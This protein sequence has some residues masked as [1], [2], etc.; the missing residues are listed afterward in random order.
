LKYAPHFLYPAAASL[1][2]EV[3]ALNRSIDYAVNKAGYK[4]YLVRLQVTLDMKR[5]R[6]PYDVI[7]SIAFFNDKGDAVNQ[8]IIIPLLATQDFEMAN[9][10]VTSNKIR[11]YVLALSMMASAVGAH[12]E[13]QK[14]IKEYQNYIT[15][16]YNSLFTIGS[17]GD[18]AISAHFGAMRSSNKNGDPVDQ[19]VSNTRT[20]NVLML[21]P[22]DKSNLKFDRVRVS[23]KSSFLHAESGMELK[24]VE[25]DDLFNN[26]INKYKAY[27][28]KTPNL[29]Y[30]AKLRESAIELIQ[31]T[32]SGKKLEFDKKF[33]E[34]LQ[35]A[36]ADE[37]ELH[38]ILYFNDSAWLDILSIA[39]QYPYTSFRF[40]VPN[41][42][43]SINENLKQPNKLIFTLKDDGENSFLSLPLGQAT[44]FKTDDL[45]L[46]VKSVDK[47][48]S[49]IAKGN[50]LYP[51]YL[52]TTIGGNVEAVYPSFKAMKCEKCSFNAEISGYGQFPVQWYEVKK[53]ESKPGTPGNAN[54]K[55]GPAAQK[56]SSTAASGLVNIQIISSSPDSLR[57][58]TQGGNVTITSP[59]TEQHDQPGPN[60]GGDKPG[61]GTPAPGSSPGGAKPDQKPQEQTTP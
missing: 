37:K 58:S 27:F 43:Y 12:A 14:V 8:P 40:E 18:N 60:Q 28:H 51:I 46:V 33:E 53:K 59:K 13:A 16:D 31:Y 38:E 39:S 45:L 42:K 44:Y 34:I 47:K 10:N 17:L 11:Q 23:T 54:A 29:Q 35:C 20:I 1:F 49:C 48:S 22:I 25:Q 24:L 56:S 32:Q 9:M 21:V 30:A 3:K 26:M 41:P 36:G 6:S 52:S 4:P 57:H 5:N 19:Q 2:Q 50:S 61:P 7:T 55:P 15:N